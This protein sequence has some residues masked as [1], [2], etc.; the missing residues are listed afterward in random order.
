MK[1]FHM[2]Y[3]CILTGVPQEA[4]KAQ[5]GSFQEGRIYFEVY[6]VCRELLQESMRR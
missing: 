4:D 3:T 6:F 1:I 2:N 5:N